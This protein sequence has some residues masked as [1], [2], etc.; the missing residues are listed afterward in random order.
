MCKFREQLEFL[1]IHW[2]VSFS[3]IEQH[4]ERMIRTGTQLVPEFRNGYLS[5]LEFTNEDVLE[6][7]T[8]DFLEFG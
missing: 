7:A 5:T 8:P 2:V 6:A 1:N 4:D 3:Y